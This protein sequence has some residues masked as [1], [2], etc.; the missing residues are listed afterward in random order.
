MALPTK[1][2]CG[3]NVMAGVLGVAKP[4]E[5]DDHVQ[6]VMSLGLRGGL[7]R[8]GN[9]GVGDDMGVAPCGSKL[10]KVAQIPFDRIEFEVCGTADRQIRVHGLHQHG[11]PSGHGLTT[12]ARRPKSTLA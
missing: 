5:A 6:T 8:P 12:C 11:T 4:S 1:H 2:P 3:W 7:P 9:G 10:G